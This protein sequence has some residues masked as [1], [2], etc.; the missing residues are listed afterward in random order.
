MYFKTIVFIFFVVIQG[1][2][3]FAGF[4]V[5]IQQ[6]EKAKTLIR[7]L[8]S[9]SDDY[10]MVTAHRGDWRNA[11]ENSIKAIKNCISMGV[12]IVEIDLKM[13]KDSILVVMHDVT[14]ERT[15]NGIGKVLDWTYD[16]LKTL[17]LLDNGMRKVKRQEIPTLE[18]AMMV[19]KGKILVNL[20]KG[21][22]YMDLAYKILVKTGTVD[23]V[24]LKGGKNLAQVKEQ[25]GPLLDKII[26][27]PVVT[28]N[29]SQLERFI[30]DFLKEQKPVA[31]EVI[32]RSDDS[33]MFSMIKKIKSGGSRVWIN[34]LSE[35]YCGKHDDERA[36]DDP[37]GSWGW[38]I[39]HGANIIQTDRP[40]M[41]IDYLKSKGLH[42]QFNNKKCNLL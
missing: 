26:Y 40:Q 34:T 33:P 5:I 32:Y 39:G 12:D 42:T 28:E 17:N 24:I 29:H 16:S 14:L 10:V 11:P 9:P 6:E 7:I 18:E 23:Q 19:A 31:F 25:Y 30:D 15:T 3:S 41:L 37:D 20:D 1:F 35:R 13:T 22:D 38:V 27:M 8:N 21:A 2:N 36:V 4:S